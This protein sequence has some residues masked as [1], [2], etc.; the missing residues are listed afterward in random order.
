[1]AGA[2]PQFR[3]STTS[4]ST[5]PDLTDYTTLP[6]AE[7]ESIKVWGS[8]RFTLREWSDKLWDQ[9]S[10]K[11]Q[12]P[13]TYERQELA[14]ELTD[15]LTRLF[16]KL[17]LGPSFENLEVEGFY[18]DEENGVQWA[19]YSIVFNDLL[20][21]KTTEDIKEVFEMEWT[22]NQHM[23]IDYLID[24]SRTYFDFD[25]CDDCEQLFHSEAGNLYF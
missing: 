20:Q 6:E 1:M 18:P 5:T 12:D 22:N 24:P 23:V 3:E 21:A 8:L 15:E 11:W 4:T 10:F 17:G 2:A 25:G 13:S 9:E 14:K 19:I 16:K 7:G